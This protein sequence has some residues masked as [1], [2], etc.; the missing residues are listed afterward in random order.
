M[1]EISHQFPL[2][3][4]VTFWMTGELDLNKYCCILTAID[5]KTYM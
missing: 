5:L 4:R 3:F 1:H 2:L